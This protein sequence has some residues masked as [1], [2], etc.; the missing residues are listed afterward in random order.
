MP[1]RKYTVRTS[2]GV[3]LPGAPYSPPKTA[4]GPTDLPE[5]ICRRPKP[6]SS[7][8]PEPKNF[9]DKRQMRRYMTQLKTFFHT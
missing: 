2:V 4:T 7:L 1:K 8:P 3:L 5:R 9:G 6:R